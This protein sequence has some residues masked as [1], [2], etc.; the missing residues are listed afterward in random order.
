MNAPLLRGTGPELLL[1]HGAGS[2]VQDSYGPLIDDLTEYRT[3][4]GPDYPGSGSTPL[5]GRPLT[6]DELADHIV[7]SAVRHGADTFAISGFSMGCSVAVRAAVR[8]PERVT[9][10]ILS[11]GFAHP[12]PRLRLAVETW[13]AL[14][15]HLPESRELAA[16]LSLMVGGP[17]WLDERSTDEIEEQLTLFA[18]GLPPGADAQLALFEHIDVRPDLARIAVPT[19]VVSPLRDLLIT[20]LHS[21]ELADGIPGARLAALD[22]GHAIAAEEPAAWAALIRDFLTSVEETPGRVR[23]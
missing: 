16:Y 5:P 23:G 3:V 4:I 13:R 1:A 2:D 6:L 7:E 10:L 11:A 18:G 9:A 19:L 22:C 15:R 8:H 17:E 14:G 21:R 12:N 20:P